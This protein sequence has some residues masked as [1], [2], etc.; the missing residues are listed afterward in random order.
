MHAEKTWV[1]AETESMKVERAAIALMAQQN[2]LN[3][4]IARRPTALTCQNAEVDRRDAELK[5]QRAEINAEKK[6]EKEKK[7]ATQQ[8]RMQSF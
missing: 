4:D 3:P 7:K 6:K 8:L 1:K 5:R 2:P